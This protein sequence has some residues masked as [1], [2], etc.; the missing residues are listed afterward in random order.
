M[1]RI[2]MILFVILILLPAALIGGCY[3][4]IRFQYRETFMPGLFVNGVYAADMTPQQ[5][6]DKLK[7]NALL[8]TCI[9][10]DAEGEEHSFSMEEAGFRE[11]YLAELQ[12]LHETQSVL[13]FVNWFLE[14]GNVSYQEK[15]LLPDVS[16]DHNKLT[17]EIRMAIICTMKHRICSIMKKPYRRSKKHSMHRNMR[18]IWQKQTAMKPLPIRVR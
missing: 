7:E 9:I 10:T 1:K 13:K 4:A 17:A 5:M 2:L 11:D 12:N 6:N 8:P 15:Q 14:N 3:G 16:Y 18:S